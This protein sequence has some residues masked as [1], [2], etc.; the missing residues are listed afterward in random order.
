MFQLSMVSWWTFKGKDVCAFSTYII[1]LWRGKRRNVH[2]V[3]F[4]YILTGN[5]NISLFSQ[6]FTAFCKVLRE[7]DIYFRKFCNQFSRI[8]VKEFRENFARNA[9]TEIFV[10]T[11][12]TYVFD[13]SIERGCRCTYDHNSHRTSVIFV[14]NLYSITVHP[15]SCKCEVN[16]C[17]WIIFTSHLTSSHI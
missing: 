3:F 8:C 1:T 10:L 7:I 4:F 16:T 14:Y 12:I 13:G 11:L 15:C 17:N 9:K 2:F 6:K 5:V